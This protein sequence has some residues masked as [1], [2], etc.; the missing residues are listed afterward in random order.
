M[1]CPRHAKQGEKGSD[2][3]LGSYPS[4]HLL[5]TPVAGIGTVRHEGE[6]GNSHFVVFQRRPN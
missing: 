4:I 3:P 5:M 1:G 2:E 6:D